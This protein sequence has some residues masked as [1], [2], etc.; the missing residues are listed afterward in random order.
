MRSP[1]LLVIADEAEAPE[2]ARSFNSGSGPQERWPAIAL[3]TISEEELAYLGIGLG[4][5]DGEERDAVADELLYGEP[6]QPFVCRVIPEF[7]DALALLDAADVR[8]IGKRWRDA[9]FRPCGG[10]RRV[11]ILASM[12][13]LARQAKVAGKSVVRACPG[14]EEKGRTRRGT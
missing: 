3:G 6:P 1:D 8:R 11:A 4:V 7:V 13:E 12:V 5:C 10:S 2:I 9:D 14:Y